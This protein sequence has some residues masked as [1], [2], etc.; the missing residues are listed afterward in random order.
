ME[1]RPY[2]P[3]GWRQVIGDVTCGI[4]EMA[5][6]AGKGGGDPNEIGSVEISWG[7]EKRKREELLLNGFLKLF[8]ELRWSEDLYFAV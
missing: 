4:E 2:G 1:E 5:R 6:T 3:Q 8:E 7:R